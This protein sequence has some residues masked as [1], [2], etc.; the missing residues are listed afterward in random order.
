MNFGFILIIFLVVGI[1]FLVFFI[2]RGIVL[3]KRAEQAANFTNRGDTLK[4]IRAAKAALE[5][6][7]QN[8]EAHYLLGKAFLADKRDEQAFREYRS[9]SRLGIGGKNIPETAFRETLAGLYAQFNEP[10]EALKEYIV[11]IK[12]YPENPDYYFNAGKIFAARNRPDLAEQ[13]LKKTVSINPR[14]G[15][16]RFELG[17]LY[18]LGKRIKEAGAEFDAALKLNPN[19]AQLLMY[20][21]KIFK[22]AKDYAGAIPYLEKASHDQDYKLR[23]IIEMG[24]CYISLKMMDKAIAELERAVALIVKEADLDSLYARYFLA[25]SYELTGN[26]PKALAQ[27][28]KIYALKKNFRDVGEKLTKYIE[29]RTATEEKES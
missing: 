10:E 9:A 17:M 27:W 29:Y 8:A 11:L 18:Y 21:G 7:P 19:D 28:D 5:K 3:P 1:G 25:M 24:S 26:I 22:D 13:Y 20:M 14:E 4:A 6:D 2:I 15:R 16:Y 23:S 12:L